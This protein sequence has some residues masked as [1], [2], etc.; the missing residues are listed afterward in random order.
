M[1]TDNPGDFVAGHRGLVGAS[2]MRL[3]KARPRTPHAQFITRTRAK[4]ELT[5]WT[6]TTPLE[7]GLRESY[8]EFL[9]C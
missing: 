4:R 9:S 8:Q 6:P 1:T 5:D 7:A 2:E 3:L